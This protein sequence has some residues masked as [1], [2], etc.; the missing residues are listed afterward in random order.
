[1]MRGSILLTAYDRPDQTL[2]CLRILYNDLKIYE[3]DNVEVIVLDDYH[4]SSLQIKDACS[5]MENFKYIHTGAQKNNTQ[6]WRV[7]GFALNVGI[8]ASKG[9]SIILGNSEIQIVK[10]DVVEVLLSNAEEGFCSSAQILSDEFRFGRLEEEQLYYYM[11]PFFLSVP[12]KV[13]IDIGGYDEDMV[14]YCWDD[15]DISWRMRTHAPFK[16]ASRDDYACKHLDNPVGAGNRGDDWIAHQPAWMYNRLISM[17]KQEKNKVVRNKNR[18]WGVLEKQY[19][20]PEE[21]T[22]PECGD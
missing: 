3:H 21:L 6:M 13:L 14:G 5:N 4:D 11:F 2:E 16:L 10:G 22:N 15:W 18:R 1:M 9:T 12:R 19:T 8:Q 7:P 20:R 17:R